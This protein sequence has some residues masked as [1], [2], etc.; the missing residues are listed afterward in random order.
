VTKQLVEPG[1]TIILVVKGIVP[2][3]TS[4]YT[5]VTVKPERPKP[6]NVPNRFSN[7]ELAEWR[8][9]EDA[10]DVY[11]IANATVEVTYVSRYKNGVYIDLDDRE[12]WMRRPD[13]WT[14]MYIGSDLRSDDGLK[15]KPVNPQRLKEER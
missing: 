3:D 2:F 9:W 1:D 14:K 10:F 8:G 13:G 6:A 15:T 4:K 7:L 11:A 12:F 5:E